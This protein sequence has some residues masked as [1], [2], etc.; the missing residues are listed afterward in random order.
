MTKA[1]GVHHTIY[2]VADVPILSVGGI[3]SSMVAGVAFGLVA[4]GFAKTT[5]T[6]SHTARRLIPSAPFR[7]F[8]GGII[9]TALVLLMGTT[10]T[11]AWEFLRSSHRS[12]PGC[13][14]T[15]SLSNLSLLLSRLER[16][17]KAE[18]SHPFSSSA[19][20]SAMHS[21]E[22]CRCPHLCLRAW[23]LLPYLP[24]PRTLPLHQHSWP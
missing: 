22:F 12:I 24:E 16:A 19:L 20:H 8:F 18:R 3:L 2:T 10:S 17:S 9:V 7:P 4:M 14:P 15:T 23:D 6:V 21:P 1:W 11:S 5:H 13:H